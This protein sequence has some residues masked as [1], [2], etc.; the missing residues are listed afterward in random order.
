MFYG[1]TGAA[2]AVVTK[3]DYVQT[4]VDLIDGYA[5]FA[6]GKKEAMTRAQN[7]TGTGNTLGLRLFSKWVEMG[8]YEVTGPVISMTI[9]QVRHTPS[10]PAPS[11]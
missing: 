10:R 5:N 8:S 11:F 4:A 9:L 6:T 3:V 7:E 2:E 1:R